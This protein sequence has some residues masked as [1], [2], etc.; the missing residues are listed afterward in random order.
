M[1]GRSANSGL[2]AQ[3]ESTATH[4]EAPALQHTDFRQGG[5]DMAQPPRA[6]G[7]VI[8]RADV[9]GLQ[10]QMGQT[11]F[12]AGDPNAAPHNKVYA[13]TSKSFN[14]NNY[15]RTG[16]VHDPH[17]NS[18]WEYLGY[19]NADAAQAVR[20]ID[21]GMRPLPENLALT[22]FVGGSALGAILGNPRITN[23]NIGRVIQSI[24]TPQGAARFAAELAAA[25]YTEK[26]YT[27]TTYVQSHPSYD[28]R[29]IRLNIVGKKGTPAIV[30]S[31]HAE[32]EVLMGRNLHYNFTGGFRVV[33]TPAG[34]QQLEID[35][36][37]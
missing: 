4:A 14:I 7:R 33:R 29:Q 1:G 37:I 27:S 28:T 31:N 22:R 8:T 3:P 2:A 9:D 5:R 12:E 19:T 24:A 15:L 20:Q 23:A 21:A 35:V 32:N 6:A 17:G 18:Q 13:K 34:V 16:S 36:E 11:G 10:R 25:N 30:T 26:G